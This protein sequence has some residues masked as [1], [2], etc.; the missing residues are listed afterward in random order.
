MASLIRI[1]YWLACDIIRMAVR[2][3]KCALALA[4]I[5]SPWL[6]EALINHLLQQ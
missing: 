5:G 2:A 6:L 4:V 1:T 3:A